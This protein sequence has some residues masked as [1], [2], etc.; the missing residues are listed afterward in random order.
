MVDQVRNLADGRLLLGCI[1]CGGRDDTRDHVPPRVFLDAPYPENLPVVG[2]CRACNNGRSRDEVYLACLIEAVIAGTADPVR[3]QRVQIAETLRRNAGLRSR[4]ESARQEIDQQITFDIEE[5]RVRNVLIKLARG[6]AAFELAVSCD[7][8]PASLTWC[9]IPLM[10][11]EQLD[12]FDASHVVQTF[13]EVGSRGMQRIMVTQVEL[14]SAATGVLSTVQLLIN[15]WVN[16]QEGRYRYLAIY[17][18]GEIRVKIIIR[19]Y[20]ACEVVWLH[21]EGAGV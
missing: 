3:I 7:E 16:V 19:N 17:D 14:K 2:A 1:Y 11:P 8:E 10:S 13:A 6:H 18:A 4:I 20:L 5:D 21:G 12:S 9:P 15:D